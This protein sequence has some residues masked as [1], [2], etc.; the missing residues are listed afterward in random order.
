[1]IIAI[2]IVKATRSQKPAPNHCA[3]WSGE[4]PDE[5]LATKTIDD[6]DE[7]Q[8]ERVGKP[9]LEPGREAQTGGLQPGPGGFFLRDHGADD[10][11]RLSGHR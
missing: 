11:T 6:G 10:I 2:C 3:V 1:M 5:Q 4:L 7:R 9:A 8:R